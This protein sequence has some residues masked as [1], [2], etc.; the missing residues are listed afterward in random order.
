MRRAL[1]LTT[2]FVLAALVSYA[3]SKHG[4]P[5]GYGFSSGR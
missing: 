4:L 1:V 3:G 5:I 2:L